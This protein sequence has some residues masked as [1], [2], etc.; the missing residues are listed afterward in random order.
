MLHFLLQSNGK[1]MFLH[2]VAGANWLDAITRQQVVVHPL[3]CRKDAH[4]AGAEG[5]EQGAVFKLVCNA[6]LD[7]MPIKPFV[8]RPR[9]VLVEDR[10]AGACGDCQGEPRL[11]PRTRGAASES[12]TCPVFL[13]EILYIGS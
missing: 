1:K 2:V 11:P 10:S 3:D 13:V 12:S 5:F 8:G 9:D 4:A 7:A 6:R